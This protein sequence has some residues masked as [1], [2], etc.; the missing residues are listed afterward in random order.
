MRS[1]SSRAAAVS[2]MGELVAAPASGHEGLEHGVEIA[3]YAIAKGELLIAGQAVQEWHEPLDRICG[4]LQDRQFAAAGGE[5]GRCTA[6]RAGA[7]VRGCRGSQVR[8]GTSCTFHHGPRR[9][10]AKAV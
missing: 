1:R 4:G 3:D 5:G 6:G 9:C 2:S 8:R 7:A 10:G